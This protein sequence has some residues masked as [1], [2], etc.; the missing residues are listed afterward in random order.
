VE[1]LV[2]F[3][4]KVSQ[5]GITKYV[6][7]SVTNSVEKMEQLYQTFGL[8]MKDYNHG[9][10]AI[11]IGAHMEG[12]FISPEKK[13]AHDLKLLMKPNIELTQKLN[14][15]ANNS[16]VMVTYAPELQDG[17]YTK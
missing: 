12:P 17:S 5:E 2:K 15:L 16:L 13:G 3:A 9:P 8:F 11:A 14:K 7:G 10:Q 4:Q 6:Q 1:S